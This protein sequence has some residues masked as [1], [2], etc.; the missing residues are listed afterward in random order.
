MA[1]IGVANDK[2]RVMPLECNP[3]S[4]EYHIG[5]LSNDSTNRINLVYGEMPFE[6]QYRKQRCSKCKYNR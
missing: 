2:L 3:A 4:R 5:R 6:T 1:E